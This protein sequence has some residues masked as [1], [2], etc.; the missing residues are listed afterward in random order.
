MTGVGV[1]FIGAMAQLGTNCTVNPYHICE[2]D[3]AWGRVRWSF[4]TIWVQ[5][6]AGIAL[7]LSA[8]W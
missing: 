8:F 2:K 7:D 4:D 5:I 1:S 6:A 3:G